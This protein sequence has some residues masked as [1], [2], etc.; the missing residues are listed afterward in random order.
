MNSVVV[1]VV[2]ATVVAV[3]AAGV[4]WVTVRSKAPGRKVFD[5][6]SFVPLAIPSTMIGL[7]L[8][9]VYL[10][11]NW[12][13]VYGTIWILVIAFVTTYLAFGTR[14]TNGVLFQISGELEES[15]HASGAGWLR[16]FREV[17]VPLMRPALLAVWIW[18]A[19]HSLRE[20][21]AALMLQGQDNTVIPTLLWGYWESGR[22]TVAAAAGVWLI[23]AL[24]VFVSLWALLARKREVDFR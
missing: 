3:L 10:T 13:P 23:V 9:F 5:A 11:I 1:A 15:A 4:S 17:T 19:A 22:P 2:A 21:S 18:V 14:V 6:I 7:A 16:T 12:I 8:I 20:L 24:F